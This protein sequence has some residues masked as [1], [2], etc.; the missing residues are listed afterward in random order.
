MPLS[1]RNSRSWFEG[2]KVQKGAKCAALDVLVKL[3]KVSSVQTLVTWLEHDNADIREA[4][5]TELGNRARHDDEQT[6]FPDALVTAQERMPR[7]ETLGSEIASWFSSTELKMVAGIGVFVVGGDFFVAQEQDLNAA[8]PPEPRSLWWGDHAARSVLRY[9]LEH[10]MAKLTAEVED[11][12]ARAHGMY[13]KALGSSASIT[14]TLLMR[15]QRTG[16]AAR[17]CSL[18]WSKTLRC[19]TAKA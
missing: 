6:G 13:W 3:A 8:T 14:V 17:V 5:V 1:W 7:R 18:A 9:A 11:P 10:H 2:V 12:R 16:P 4:A 19:F 15:S